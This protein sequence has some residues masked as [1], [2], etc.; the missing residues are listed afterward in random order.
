MT[1][2]QIERE[3]EQHLLPGIPMAVPTHTSP[4][5]S[6]SPGVIVLDKTY[7]PTNNHQ[8]T[9]IRAEVEDEDVVMISENGPD[10]NNTFSELDKYQDPPQTSAP[11]ST[12]GLSSLSNYTSDTSNNEEMMNNEDSNPPHPSP[13]QTNDSTYS[14]EDSTKKNKRKLTVHEAFKPEEEVEKSHK[15][16]KLI[17]LNEESNSSDGK[18]LSA[19]EKR[20]WI[21]SFIDQIPV[22]KDN[23]FA[24]EVDWSLVDNV[25]VSCDHV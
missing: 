18:G 13:S 24:W 21:K 8:D 12:E 15:K 20:K 17:P 14:N 19:E 25:S 7:S 9:I 4:Q 5:A 1:T 3:R 23:L 11:I 16:Q 22:E 10:K 2:Q 6:Y